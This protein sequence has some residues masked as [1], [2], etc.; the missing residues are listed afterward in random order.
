MLRTQ[1]LAANTRI[2]KY[3]AEIIAEELKVMCPTHLHEAWKRT[4]CVCVCVRERVYVCVWER[5]SK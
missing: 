3:S 5:A 1:L 4:Q 2:E